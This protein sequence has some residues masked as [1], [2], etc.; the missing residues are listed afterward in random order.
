MLTT[1]TTTIA[2]LGSFNYI[3]TEGA[4]VLRADAPAGGGRDRCLPRDGPL[5]LL[6]LLRAHPRADVLHRRGLGRRRRIYAAI[7]F[8]LYTA[9]GSLLMLVG[10]LYL[11]WKAKTILGMPSFAYADLLS[12][13]LTLHR[14]ALAL[15]RIRL[16]VQRQGAG[17]PAPH[18]AAR[19]TR[20]G[21]DARAR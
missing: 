1:F 4:G 16:G 7:K 11:F 9:F 2:I 12:V 8:F 6:R 19:R 3:K 10:I 15:Q 18:L 20:R 13:P 5:P 21:T 17:L 14:A